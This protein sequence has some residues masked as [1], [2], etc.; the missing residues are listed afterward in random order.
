MAAPD[1]KVIAGECA[2]RIGELGPWLG[3]APWVERDGVYKPLNTLRGDRNPG[4][5]VI[6]G[7]RHAKAGGWIEYATGDK[8]DA[9][10]LIA[11]VRAGSPKRRDI[12]RAEALRFL[13][14]SATDAPA[15]LP[16]EAVAELAAQRAAAEAREAA[17]IAAKRQRAKGSWLHARPLAA[18]DV[19]TTYLAGRGL[20]LARLGAPPRA[21][22]LEPGANHRESGQRWPAM[23]AMITGPDGACWGVHRTFL[24]ADGSGKAPVNPPRKIWPGGFW[25]GAIR[26]SRGASNLA[27]AEAAAKGH[28]DIVAIT[29][30]VEDA[31][32][33]AL[34]CPDW[35]VWAAGA[36]GAMGAIDPPP[37][38]RAIVL[39]R[40]NDELGKDGVA[41]EAAHKAWSRVL[42][43]AAGR[44]RA[45]GVALY[46]ARPKG[47]AKDFNDAL[48]ALARKAAADGA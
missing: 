4:S 34:A 3:L 31:L 18:G 43:Q 28:A 41:L 38:C 26:I 5:W 39:I 8:G 20:D 13:G 11:Y 33:V 48:Q 12:G 17:D 42:D 16:P 47:G 14:W 30:G 45:A 9:I 23:I 19:V 44:C 27:P 32:T 35:R 25:G 29:E 36:L 46:V 10:D 37:G 22:R 21:L 40:D 2:R 24:A 6:Y 1:I 7:A 15:A